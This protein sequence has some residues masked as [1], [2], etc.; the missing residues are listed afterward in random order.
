M[1]RGL[2]SGASRSTIIH[3]VTNLAG[4][5]KRARR[6]HEETHILTYKLGIAGLGAIGMKVA[7]KIDSGAIPGIA[8]AAVSANDKARAAAKVAGFAAPP[9]VCTLAELSDHADIVIECAPASVFAEVAGPAVEKGRMFMPLSVG[10][11]LNHM[12]LVDR[13]RETGARIIVP[14]GAI[15]GLDTVRAMAVG[16]ITSVRL[17][18]RKPPNGLAGAPYLVENDIDVDNLSEALCVFRGSAREAARAFPANVNVAAALG[19]AGVGPDKTTIEVWADPAMDR[20]QQTVTIES[21]TGEATMQ[22]RNV[23]SAENPRTGK[24]VANSVLATLDRLT[25]PLVAGT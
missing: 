14:T 25:A 7:G 16:E 10:A 17:E 6:A 2:W 11:L 24:I 4:A 1:L 22:I 20:N 15:I 9:I 3:V 23:P 8:L 19:L 12:D 13:A 18:T 21:D 5:G